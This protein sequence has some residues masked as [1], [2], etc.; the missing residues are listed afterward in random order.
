MLLYLYFRSIK[1]SDCNKVVIGIYPEFIESFNS[2][3]RYYDII[4]FLEKI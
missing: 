4:F 2:M 3:L 1:T